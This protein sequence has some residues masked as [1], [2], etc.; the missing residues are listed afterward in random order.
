MRVLLT[1]SMLVVA[2]LALGQLGHSQPAPATPAE[3]KVLAAEVKEIFRAHCLECHG[4]A[5][6]SGRLKIHDH[7]LLVVKKKLVVPG[8]PD[9]SELFGRISDTSEARMPEPPREA[10]TAD[11]IEKVR[12][13]IVAGAPAFPVDV[14]APKEEKKEPVFAGKVGIEHVLRSIL[15]HIRD[16]PR[17]DRAFFRY[18]SLNHILTSG[19]TE[20]E[21]SRQRDALV[22]AINHLSW[23]EAIY[24][25]VAIDA[26]SNTVYAVDIRKVGWHAQPFRRWVAGK[27]G[28]RSPITLFDLVLLEYPYG[29]TY[30]GSE[31]FD[32]LCEEYLV[33]GR[34][35]RP[36]PFLRAD[37]FVSVVTQPPIYDDL[38]Q[39]PLELPQLE[40]RL[41]VDSEGDLRDGRA[42][43]A[44][45]IQSGVSRNNRVVERHPARGLGY[46]WKSA[47][48]RTSKGPEN[49][50]Q[51]P[52][53]LHPAGGEMIFGLPN[54]LQAYYVATGA[55]TRLEF[56]P[57]DIVTDK[58]ATDRVVRNGLACMRCHDAGM[59]SFKDT[60]RPAL[61]KLPAEPGFDKA[62]AL[63]LY[64]EEG[65]EKEPVNL[66]KDLRKDAARFAEAMKKVL[67]REMPAG[68]EPLV[69]VS[70]RYLD[71][72]LT[73][74]QAAGELGL[75]A[76]GDL[77][78]IFR[79]PQF[80]GLGL[81][82]LSIEK[83]VVR[84]D[85]WEDYFDQVVSALGLGQPLPALDAQTRA[86]FPAGKVQLPVDLKS[87]HKNNLFTPG[88]ALFFQVVN[89][90]EKPVY[91]ELIG[92]G[93]RGEKVVLTPANLT[94]APGTTY[95]F[96]TEGTI[97]VQ[98]GLGKELVT[99]Y[100]SPEAF[101]AGELIRFEPR[102][103]YAVADRVVHSFDRLEQQGGR[104]RVVRP[105]VVIKKTLE[106]ET[107]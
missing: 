18:F 65:T 92:T 28:E 83:G 105:A 26:P 17:E 56:A 25:P 98:G 70:R 35:L 51:D 61:L 78:A 106:I 34:L 48:F 40:G 64:P 100:A 37:W 11:Q 86:N 79:I 96:P 47:D 4:G 8:S 60:V 31:M 3:G 75:E 5:R 24:Q 42:F 23:E 89:R 13:W 93:T 20:E 55:G 71:D 103:G 67:G 58:F 81:F 63:R 21:L 69:P 10:L 38:L 52:I 32:R 27:Q 66:Q 77:A 9:K 6:V 12:R 14:V 30:P 54:G 36:I 73:L 19:A 15:T 82:P 104:W 44:G 90:S 84:R 46:Y 107:R 95:R 62:Y 1:L 91:I 88:D 57:T 33:P 29:I 85:A 80:S 97:K 2:L 68:Y 39:L 102:E 99:L 72:A 87:N 76:P 50:F 16:V 22:K 49:M 74:E 53:D 45:M 59:K 101:T 94:V 41:G 7:E 43:R